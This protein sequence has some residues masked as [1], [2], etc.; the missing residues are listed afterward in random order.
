MT[1]SCFFL[2]LAT[3]LFRYFSGQEMGIRY[4]RGERSDEKRRKLK[5]HQGE[6]S[7]RSVDLD[8]LGI[9]M[10]KQLACCVF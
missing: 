6:M 8:G 4:V 5:G 1:V 7:V 9:V 10:R 3:I 2:I